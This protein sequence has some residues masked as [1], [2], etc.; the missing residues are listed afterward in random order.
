VIDDHSPEPG[1]FEAMGG[2]WEAE[3]DDE[4]EEL[5]LLSASSSSAG[6]GVCCLGQQLLGMLFGTIF[7]VTGSHMLWKSSSAGGGWV[8]HVP[9]VTLGTSL[10]VYAAVTAADDKQNP[11]LV[12]TL[13][14]GALICSTLIGWTL[15]SLIEGVEL[16][17]C[18]SAPTSG[19]CIMIVC[20]VRWMQ[21]RE[22]R[23]SA[24]RREDVTGL[25]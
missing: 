6:V 8:A 20:G 18:M 13:L 12:F 14:V 10:G 11:L 7:G 3:D 2:K 15:S 19:V 5:L 25:V 16:S 17:L 22:R 1:F 21:W 4:D 24:K 23:A 9:G